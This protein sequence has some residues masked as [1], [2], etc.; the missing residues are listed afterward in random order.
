MKN[1]LITIEGCDGAGKSTAIKHALNYLQSKKYWF[2]KKLENPGVAKL[3]IYL[4]K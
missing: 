2:Y 4:E 3:V 1:I